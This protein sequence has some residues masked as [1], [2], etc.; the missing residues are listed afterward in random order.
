VLA[1]EVKDVLLLDVTPLSLGIET[2]GGV[3][4]KLIE[5]NTTIP[6]RKGETFTTAD[7]NQNSVEIKVY[8]G[9]REIAAYNKLIG[10]FQLVGIPPAPRGVPQI[11]VAFD[12]DANGIVNV[13]A[14]DLGTGKEQ[15]ITITAS[16]GLSDSEIQQMMRDAESH[17]EEDR[18]RKEEA[19]VRNNADNLVYSVERSLKDVDGKVDPN[20]KLEIEQA[21]K[22]AKEALAGGDVEEIKTKQ[23]ALMTAS[24]KLSEALYSQAQEQQ[25]SASSDATDTDDLVEDAE[26]VEDENDGQDPQDGERR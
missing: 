15:R 10:N 14:K 20:T 7:D 9:E 18:R 8:Q 25:Q 17:A 5:R 6:T 2:K 16:G 13:G 3:F 12:I 26:V 19:D 22:E 24:H 23:E 4:T 21:I 1:G 11:E